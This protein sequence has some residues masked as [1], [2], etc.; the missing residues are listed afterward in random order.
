MI[1]WAFTLDS[2]SQCQL[3]TP[4]HRRDT[5]SLS[6][7]HKDH[8]QWPVWDFTVYNSYQRSLPLV[9]IP[10]QR[11]LPSYFDTNHVS[12]SAFDNP[13]FYDIPNNNW[14]N[15]VFNEDFGMEDSS[16]ET[17]PEGDEVPC[18]PLKETGV[19]ITFPEGFFTN[20]F[21]VTFPG[22]L[23]CTNPISMEQ[24]T[25]VSSSSPLRTVCHPPHIQGGRVE[26]VRPKSN[27]SNTNSRTSSPFHILEPQAPPLTGE[28]RKPSGPD[29]SIKY[30]LQI[31]FVDMADKKGAQRIRNTMNSRKHRQNKLEKIREL[32]LKLA[33]LEEEKSTWHDR[34]KDLGW[35]K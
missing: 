4:S 32:E 21:A 20:P 1:W 19:S 22:D 15:V 18:E 10:D 17:S 7:H 27:P 28:D 6:T 13:D 25:V 14:Q 29:K 3:P 34:A 12:L 16:L 35:K 5:S 11:N 30:G 26:K 23:P 2:D 31:H 33:A 8:S 9:S 24:S